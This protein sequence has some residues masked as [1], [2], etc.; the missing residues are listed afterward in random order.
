[1]VLGKGKPYFVI[2]HSYSNEK[3]SEDDILRLLVFSIDKIFVMF[4]G[5]VIYKFGDF[6]DHI[7]P[8]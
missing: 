1:M 5:R 2:N 7:Y 6:V 3:Y 8:I 4:G